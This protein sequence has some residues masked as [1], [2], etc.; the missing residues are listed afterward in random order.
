MGRE[1]M[2]TYSWQ[3]QTGQ[4]KALLE[5]EEIVLRGDIKTRIPRHAIFAAETKA[6]DLILMVQG[7]P[8]VLGI[9]AAEAEKWIATLRNP[10]PSLAHKLGISAEKPAYVMGLCDDPALLEALQKAQCATPD[11]AAILIAMLH[12][13]ADLAQASA[14]AHSCPDL[15]VWCVHG[16]GRGA[17][18]TDTM[19][20]SFMYARNYRDSKSCAVSTDWT[21]TRYGAAQ[22]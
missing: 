1:A 22:S 17:G 4:G 16:K 8:L 20:R 12:A 7:T 9:G 11:Q 5:A 13:E 10:P 3:G 15:Q 21:A 2:C 19:V 18:V 6:D 14:L